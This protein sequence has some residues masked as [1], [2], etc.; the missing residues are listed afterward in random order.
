[1]STTVVHQPLS[2]KDFDIDRAEAQNTPCG[3][4]GC[5][6]SDHESRIPQAEWI[7]EVVDE[8]FDGNTIF[9]S[10]SITK[11]IAAGYMDHAGSRDMTADE[12]RAAAD[13]Y[14]SYPAWL[15]NMADRLD[16]LAA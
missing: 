6:G 15:R 10:L 11:G 3:V 5:N 8:N 1:M 9:A 12:F 4:T 2:D 13:L 14:E 7:H 16:A